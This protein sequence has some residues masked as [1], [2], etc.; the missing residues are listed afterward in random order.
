MS[1]R[2]PVILIRLLLACVLLSGCGR[3]SPTAPEAIAGL[4]GVWEGPVVAYPAGED[5][6]LVRL[7]VQVNGSTLSGTLVSRNG[8]SHPV[9]GTVQDGVV[10]MEIL[11]L[12]QQTPCSVVLA[13]TRVT[14]SELRG[15][16]SGRCAN[17]LMSEFRLSKV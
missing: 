15:R 16:V 14:R 13:V 11:N 3:S 7:S 1:T 12:P 17:T 6:S 2:A 8:V 9:T 5:W 10:T 4:T